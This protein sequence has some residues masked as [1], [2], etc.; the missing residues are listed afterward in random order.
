MF[1]DADPSLQAIWSQNHTTVL[2]RPASGD[3]YVKTTYRPGNKEWFQNGRT[4]RSAPTWDAINK[5]WR[6]PKSHFKELSRRL[7][8]RFSRAYIIQHYREKEVCAPA[9]WNAMGLDCECS[10]LG[11]KHGIN[12]DGG[13]WYI[14]SETY[15][16]RWGEERLRWN[17]IQL[18]KQ[19]NHLAG[20]AAA[21]SRVKG[22]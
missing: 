14:V 5:Y 16:V 9:C 18:K 20:L 7:V 1:A 21:I 11:E 12:Q 19:E 8:E 15:A 6:V 13:R 22:Y 3:L 2:Y 10:C 17:L 4:R